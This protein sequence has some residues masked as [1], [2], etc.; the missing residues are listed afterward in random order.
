MGEARRNIPDELLAEAKVIWERQ[1]RYAA[2]CN[3]LDHAESRVEV[4]SEVIGVL[5]G[6]LE[7][8]CGDDDQMANRSEVI[9][10]AMREAGLVRKGTI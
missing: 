1:D 7:S 5:C 2:K 9:V 3:D 10:V 6:M 4:L 8:A